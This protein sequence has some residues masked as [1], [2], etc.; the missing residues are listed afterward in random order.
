MV[1]NPKQG[2]KD[3]VNESRALSKQRHIQPSV[4]SSKGQLKHIGK[5]HVE[6]HHTKN[7]QNKNKNQ[8]LASYRE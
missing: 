3:D 7:K 8:L 1:I 5:T 6:E 2:I 4:S